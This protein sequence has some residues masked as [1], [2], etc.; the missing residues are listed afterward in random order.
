VADEG[1][2][3]LCV[4]ATSP[5]GPIAVFSLPAVPGLARPAATDVAVGATGSLFVTVR[6]LDDAANQH[7]AILYYPRAK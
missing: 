3:T 2:G 6:D 7:G 5:E 4:L 1:T